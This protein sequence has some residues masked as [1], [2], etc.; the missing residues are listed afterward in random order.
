MSET[1][2]ITQEEI[3][4]LPIILK[5]KKKK[6]IKWHPKVIDNEHLNKKKS[7][8]CCTWNPSG[9]TEH[10]NVIKDDNLPGNFGKKYKKHH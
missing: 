9:C 4:K 3:K 10:E 7:K 8:C 6:K 1:V 5:L 2:V